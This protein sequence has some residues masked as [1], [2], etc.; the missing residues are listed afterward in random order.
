MLQTARLE[1]D[2]RELTL[3]IFMSGSRELEKRDDGAKIYCS[4]G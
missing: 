4:H 1:N 2:M 3:F